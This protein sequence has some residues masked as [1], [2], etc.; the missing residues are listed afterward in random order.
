MT[1]YVDFS[2][3]I[4]HA[5]HNTLFG[6]IQRVQLEIA[7]ALASSGEQIIIFGTAGP[8]FIELTRFF[9]TRQSSPA[10]DLYAELKSMMNPFSLRRSDCEIKAR[11]CGKILSRVLAYS[12]YSPLPKFQPGDL[13]F[14]GGAFW[15]TRRSQQSYESAIRS[16]AQLLVLLH[17]V[18]PIT[19][20]TLTDYRLRS[21]FARLLR[22]PI[23]VMT[24]SEF[25][26]MDLCKARSLVHSAA[27]I[28][29]TKVVPLAHEFQGA[30]RN[31]ICTEAPSSRVSSLTSFVLS[32]GTVEPRKNHIALLELWTALSKV[33][34]TDLPRLVI[35]GRRT[36]GAKSTLDILEA[37]DTNSPFR[38]VEG[39][40]EAEL[41]WLYS[42]AAFTV[43]PSL[44]EGWGLPVGE[45]LW[46]GKPCAASATTS[47][48]EVG[49]NLCCY[50]DPQNIGTFREPI[51]RLSQDHDFRNAMADKIKSSKLRTWKA[52]A[53]EAAT[54]IYDVY[55]RAA[56]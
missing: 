38:L 49:G 48:P 15:A 43:F 40:D 33:H 53:Q 41:K 50:A 23:H 31:Q 52:Y 44:A 18:I 46:F 56:R 6:G 24:S 42:N 26:L 13:L 14:V 4:F 29:S 54:H 20:H 25:T 16:G 39:P 1:L 22:L 27:P 30:T 47:I 11:A 12:G 2:D 21:H 19:F 28:L 35:A 36:R 32:V 37:A 17:D 45:S 8:L 55:A 10:C 5:R 3:V 34:A 9:R 7:R 51:E